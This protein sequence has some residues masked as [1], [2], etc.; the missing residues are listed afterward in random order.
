MFGLG[1]LK[2]LG[3]QG[4]VGGVVPQ[5]IGLGAAGL[6]AQLQLEAGHAV[7]QKDQL[8]APVGHVHGPLGG[9]PQG[10]P[11]KG[12]APVQVQHMDADVFHGNHWKVLPAIV[13]FS[14]LTR[15]NG[16]SNG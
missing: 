6:L 14:I 8:P 13:I 4:H 2:V 3:H 11:V 15:E 16:E 10:I 7:P 12:N 5:N 9:Q 1:F